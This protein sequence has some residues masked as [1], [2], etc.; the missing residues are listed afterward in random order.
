MSRKTVAR[1]NPDIHAPQQRAAKPGYDSA[2][3]HAERLLLTD[4]G[5]YLDF[6]TLAGARRMAPRPR[7]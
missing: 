2:A 1:D 4:L 7:R 6:Y 3:D 5:A